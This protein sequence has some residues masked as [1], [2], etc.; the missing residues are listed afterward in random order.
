[1]GFMWR[2]MASHPKGSLTIES[3]HASMPTQINR[4]SRVFALLAAVVTVEAL[5][6]GSLVTV[7]W[8]VT[9]KAELP[10]SPRNTNCPRTAAAALNWGTPNR[11]ADF[12]H[13]SALGNFYVYNGPGHAGNGRRTPDAVSF[14]NGVMT[15]TGDAA[16]NSAGMG[17]RP[18]QLYGRWEAC[19]KSPAGAA[20]YHPVLLLWPDAD[21]TPA[22]GEIDFMEIIDPTRQTVNAFLHHG[23]PDQQEGGRVAIDATQWHSWAVEWTS[24]R[25][26]TYV[27]G[28]PWW[29]TTNS[30][31]FP[32]RPMHLCIQLD[33]F[34]GDTSQGGYLMVEWARQYP[35]G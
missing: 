16:G 22:G 14:S 35:N 27:D 8:P 28:A 12:D 31:H 17:W 19:V 13:P 10:D 2:S 25:I 23:P 32:P 30:A 34:G 1:M 18:G 21:D 4:R 33:N 5:I 15:I 26:V 20:T 3:E 29:S 9:V 11:T 6:I 7:K 24:D